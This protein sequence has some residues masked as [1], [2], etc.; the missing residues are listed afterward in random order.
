[1][2]A[3]ENTLPDGEDIAVPA[4]GEQQDAPVAEDR[5]RRAFAADLPLNPLS[6]VGS[7]FHRVENGEMVWQG[8]V[9]GE[10]QAGKYLCQVE[11]ALPG[12]ADAKVQVIVPLDAMLSKDEGYEWRFYDSEQAMV[13]AFAEWVATAGRERV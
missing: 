12:A 6:L 11:G 8:I 2:S 10:P 5:D 9:V 4:A 13:E 3:V 7:Y 1:M